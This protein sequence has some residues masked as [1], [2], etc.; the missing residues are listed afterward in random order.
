M[1]ERMFLVAYRKELD[2]ANPSFPKPTHCHQLPPGYESSRQVAL[3]LLNGL[4][5]GAHD[6]VEPPATSGATRP[7]V[8]AFDAIGDLPPIDARR[9]I[10][11][12]RLTHGERA[13][14]AATITYPAHTEVGSIGR[15]VVRPWQ[16]RRSPCS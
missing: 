2:I 10:S 5:A 4:F 3:R 13:F 12:G 11:E 15:G 6:Y 1:R 7:A 14:D 16:C 8:T 9:E